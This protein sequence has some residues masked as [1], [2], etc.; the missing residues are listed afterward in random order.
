M[1]ISFEEEAASALAERLNASQAYRGI[2]QIDTLEALRSVIEDAKEREL[3]ELA[4]LT[5]RRLAKG[6]YEA[7]EKRAE[8]FD[9]AALPGAAA[10]PAL[11]TF[12][13]AE[14]VLQGPARFGLLLAAYLFGGCTWWLC[15]WASFV[16]G[17]RARRGL[18]KLGKGGV[19]YVQGDLYGYLDDC[20]LGCCCGNAG[21]DH[22][23]ILPGCP[24]RMAAS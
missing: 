12:L 2:R 11:L 19:D 10:L 3:L 18:A 21:C 13:S 22:C 1:S 24:R 7:M 5:Q 4:I 15:R 16:Y 20:R 6:D 8:L 17:G 9:K 23:F 14:Q